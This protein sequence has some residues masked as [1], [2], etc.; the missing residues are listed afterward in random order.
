MAERPR[1]L[2][3]EWSRLTPQDCPV[4]RGRSL[5]AAD[6]ALLARLA[7]RSS[8]RVE[9]LRHGLRIEV[10][11]HVG[12]V[13]LSA[14]RLDILPKLSLRH[15]LAMAGRVFALPQWLWADAMSSLAPGDEGLADLLGLALLRA[16]RA[17]ERT[18]LRQDYR[19]REAALAAPRGR[20][21]FDRLERFGRRRLYC[22]YAEPDPATLVNRV[23]AGGVTQV[24]RLL[25]DAGLEQALRRLAARLFTGLDPLPADTHWLRQA[26]REL[27]MRPGRDAAYRD[28]LTLLAL[29]AQGEYPAQPGEGPALGGFLLDMNALFEWF[30][31]EHLRRHAPPGLQIASQETRADAFAYLDNP[32]RW[33]RPRIRPDLVFRRAGCPIAVGDAK[34]RDY[35]RQPPGS[36]ELFQ[37]TAYGLAYP[38][39]EPRQVLLFHPLADGEEASSATL[40]FAPG[41]SPHRVHIRLVG[42]PL[43][44]LLEGEGWWPE[45]LA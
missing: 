18:G 44:R 27:L 38:L 3:R 15:W 4:L 9:E 25:L 40:L 10:G 17:L 2:L 39:P 34:Y 23:L 22:R 33:H 7:A 36:G 45:G 20:L 16:L 6:R 8:L 5:E 31:D 37:L 14:L 21:R 29:L 41:A 19:E 13:T 28:A 42:V 35:R 11:P 43:A 12:T 26:R 32:L 30:L 24:C 1:L